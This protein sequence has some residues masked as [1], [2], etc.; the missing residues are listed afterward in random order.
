[1]KK[2]KTG[3]NI[4][5]FLGLFVSIGV[6]A[7]AGWNLA[8][9]YHNYGQQAQLN[10]ELDNVRQ[11]AAEAS[12]EASTAPNASHEENVPGKDYKAQYEALKKRNEDYVAWLEIEDTNISYPIVHR[13]NEFYLKHD[14]KQERNSHGC[15]FL[16]GGCDEKDDIWLIHGHHMKDGTMFGGLKQFEKKD[17]I[18]QHRKLYIE[19]KDG[20]SRYQIYAVALIDFTKEEEENIFHYEKLPRDEDELEQ[21]QARLKANSFW[22]DDTIENKRREEEKKISDREIMILSTCEYHTSLQRLIV[23]AM[24]ER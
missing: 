11:G 9:Y 2:K 21:Y 12:Y 1:M 15:I 5:F 22:Y 4:V 14:F 24:R 17:Y 7:Y 16:D 8:V 13:D 6:F 3:S 18:E 10:N 23:V 19:A 20:V